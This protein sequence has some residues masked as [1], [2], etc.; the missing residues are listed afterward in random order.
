M[1]AKLSL[2]CF[3]SAIFLAASTQTE[4]TDKDISFKNIF[5][6]KRVTQKEVANIFPKEQYGFKNV[7]K[8][9]P[10]DARATYL[11]D[12]ETIV[13]QYTGTATV[14]VENN[15]VE[16]IT[17]SF[18]SD[19]YKEIREALVEKYGNPDESD[20]DILKNGY[21]A[22]FT[23]ENLY[24]INNKKDSIYLTNIFGMISRS[25]LIMSTQR[26][27]TKEQAGR[28]LKGGDL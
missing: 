6:G 11:C 28:K 23:A 9:C 27:L 22:S 21:G 2:A 26:Y 4:A 16:E 25:K 12:G 7:F 18:N 10:D 15:I 5:L 3:A 8:S 19:F 14:W 1:K 13:G 20:Q 17:F 24:W